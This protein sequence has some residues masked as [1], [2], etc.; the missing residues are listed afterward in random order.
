MRK[1]AFYLS[2]LL[3]LISFNSAAIEAQSKFDYA[4]ELSLNEK[5]DHAKQLYMASGKERD[6]IFKEN[7]S[8]V[9]NLHKEDSKSQNS[10]SPEEADNLEQ[11]FKE[12]I[13]KNQ[14]ENSPQEKLVVKADKSYDANINKMDTDDNEL[15]KPSGSPEKVTTETKM[16][17]Q[18]ISLSQDQDVSKI[19]KVDNSITIEK[20]EVARKSDKKVS[21]DSNEPIDN[22]KVRSDDEVQVN[23]PKLENKDTKKEIKEKTQTNYHANHIYVNGQSVAYLDLGIDNYNIKKT[24][25]YIDSGHI[26]STVTKF[27]PNDN[28]ITY[29]SGHTYNYNGIANLSLESIITVTDNEGK[30]YKYKV[31]DYKKYPAGEVGDDAP[32]IGGHSLLDLAGSGIG[33]EGIVIQYCDENDVPVIFLALA[34]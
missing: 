10:L 7:R 18:D 26:I 1:L 14:I 3:M 16:S 11:L 6:I 29:F 30:G 15:N 23:E 33:Q 22:K 28:E 20:N 19:T 32:R 4:E 31:V 2:I 27:D 12:G 24:Q 9:S 8:Y 21:K 13:R 25:A 5:I 17:K 34:N